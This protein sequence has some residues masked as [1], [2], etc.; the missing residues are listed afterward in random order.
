MLNKFF[1]E[2]KICLMCKKRFRPNSSDTPYKSRSYCPDCCKK[3]FNKN[4]V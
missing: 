2:V 4:E 1:K 3:Y